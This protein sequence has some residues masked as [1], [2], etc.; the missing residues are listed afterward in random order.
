M[1]NA[2]HLR[3]K[4]VWGGLNPAAVSIDVKAGDLVVFTHFQSG[5]SS[6][7]NLAGVTRA[8]GGS[9]LRSMSSG[10]SSSAILSI[11]RATEDYTASL[12]AGTIDGVDGTIGSSYAGNTSNA[13]QQIIACYDNVDAVQWSGD[14]EAP[15][16]AK[17]ATSHGRPK[18]PY[19]Q[20]WE[21]QPTAGL[22]EATHIMLIGAEVHTSVD[23][24]N[25]P[26]FTPEGEPVWEVAT[27][28]FWHHTVTSVRSVEVTDTS[29]AFSYRALPAVS[30]T[31]TAPVIAIPMVC[32]EAPDDGGGV[33]AFNALTMGDGT[34]VTLEGYWD[35]TQLLPAE[36]VGLATA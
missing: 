6:R 14:F 16:T 27:P 7:A 12:Y 26:T 24:V 33:D 2:P 28:S 21:I 32:S 23:N 18:N 22:T 29:V 8:M 11:C 19:S 10:A 4:I 36:F 9:T 30:T 35:G 17:A 20:A 1:G 15:F 25:G 31:Y 34:P 13:V 5:T 3:S